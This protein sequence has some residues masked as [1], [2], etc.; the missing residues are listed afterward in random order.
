MRFSIAG[1]C[2]AALALGGAAIADC[3]DG[4]VHPDASAAESA[5]EQTV[6]ASY[7]PTPAPTAAVAVTAEKEPAVEPTRAAVQLAPQESGPREPRV[8]TK[9]DPDLDV[10]S[11]PSEN[12]SILNG[13]TRI[14]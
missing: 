12:G 5:H 9:A 7:E 3:G 8:P 2:I 6:Q 11:A 10:Q 13:R 14:D 4:G 1:M